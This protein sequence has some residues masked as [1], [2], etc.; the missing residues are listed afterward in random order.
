M[1]TIFIT[2]ASGGIGAALARHFAR[3]GWNVAAGGGSRKAELDAICAEITELGGKPLAMF[4]D[5]ADYGLVSGF[6]DEIVAAFGGI[7]VVINNAAIAHTGYFADMREA[8]WR[9]L[10]D[11]NLT[12]VINCCHAAIRHMLKDGRGHIINISSIWG[13]TGA[14]CEAV[15][16]MTKGGVDAFTRALAKELGPAN[17]RVNAIACGLIDTE[18]NSALTDDETAYFVGRIPL[19]RQGRPD[20]VARV[21]EFLLEADYVTGQVVTMDGGYV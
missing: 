8:D 1:K 12:G 11:V 4:G 10:L 14:S 17:I 19:G 6:F 16:S 2:G 3:L 5:V 13:Q 21:A 7:D 18:M 20:E 15:Y 9:R